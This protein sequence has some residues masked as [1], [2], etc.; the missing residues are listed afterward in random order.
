M[1]ARITVTAKEAAALGLGFQLV[2]AVQMMG[3]S[4]EFM[5]LAGIPYGEFEVDACAVGYSDE[6][7]AARPAAEPE[8]LTKWL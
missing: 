2:S 5:E 3:E 4:R 8:R 7:P 6:E 1:T